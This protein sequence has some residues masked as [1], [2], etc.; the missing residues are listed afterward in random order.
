M[1]V[2]PLDEWD[3]EQIEALLAR[4]PIRNLFVS[5]R[6]EAAR[7]QPGRNGWTL[8]GCLEDGELISA[9]HVGNNLVPV[10]ATDAALKA[11]SRV[12]TRRRESQSI[13]GPRDQVLALYELL[14]K[15]WGSEWRAPRDIR[16]HQ[17]VM[18][19]EKDPDFPGDDRIHQVQRRHIDS[20]FEAAVAMYKEEVG[21]DPTED[22]YSYRRYVQMLITAGRAF[23]ALDDTGVWFKSDLGVICGKSA[24]IQGVWLRPALRGQGLSVPALAQVVKLA[25]Q[26]YPTLSLYVNDFNTRAVKAYQRVGFRQVDEFATILY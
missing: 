14:I 5:S 9:L 23:G 2:R 1:E 18:L 15:R 8:W 20:Y 17:P 24:Q 7:L 3:R 21:G 26:D 6:L 10:E 22:G 12:L 11:F 19:I 25:R 4:N 16:P 13:V